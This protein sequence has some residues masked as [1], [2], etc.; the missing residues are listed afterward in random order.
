VRDFY[1]TEADVRVIDM[2]TAEGAELAARYGVT[3]VPA[4]VVN[5]V[6]KKGG[7]K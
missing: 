4:V 6:V 7:K 5:G 2:H 3:H 1:G